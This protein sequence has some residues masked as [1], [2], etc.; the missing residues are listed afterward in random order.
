M[1]FTEALTHDTIMGDVRVTMGT[2]GQA[3]GDTGGAIDVKM[4]DV[5]Y[6][7]C[8]GMV[9]YSISGTDITVTTLNPGATVIGHWMAMGYS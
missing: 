5:Y 2:I 4:S 3:S 6:F 8:T 9:N 1:A 7:E